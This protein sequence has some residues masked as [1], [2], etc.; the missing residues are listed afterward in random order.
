MYFMIAK[1][2][3]ECEAPA[4]LWI[5]DKYIKR[6]QKYNSRTENQSGAGVPHSKVRHSPDKDKYPEETDYFK[7]KI[8]REYKK[9]ESRY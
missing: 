8:L 9:K 4:S 6:W 5:K 1:Q 3:L 2:S 7:G